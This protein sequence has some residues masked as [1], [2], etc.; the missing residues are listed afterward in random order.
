MK[1][2][3]FSSQGALPPMSREEEVAAFRALRAGDESQRERIC[4][5]NLKF[6]SNVADTLRDRNLDHDDLVQEGTIGLLRAMDHFDPE[7]GIKFISYAVWTI[8]QQMDIAVNEAAFIVRPHNRV[9]AHRE[10]VKCQRKLEQELG[11]PVDIMEANEHI[12][13]IL[14]TWDFHRFSSLDAAMY[15]DGDGLLETGGKYHPEL[16]ATWEEEFWANLDRDGRIKMMYTAMH[17]VCTERERDMISL[18]HWLSDDE[19]H[20]WTLQEIGDKYS[21]SR[22]RVRQ[23]LEASYRKIKMS[24]RR[25]RYAVELKEDLV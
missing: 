16:M 17:R 24:I 20:E 3:I 22:E 12:Q 8:Y 19:D 6:I 11:R 7:R 5:A 23:I 25:I 21:L 14:K 15:E 18:F 1:Q 4:R 2:E 9:K 13:G 10:V